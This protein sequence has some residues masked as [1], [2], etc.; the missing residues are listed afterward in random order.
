MVPDQA[1]HLEIGPPLSG[2]PVPEDG[3]GHGRNRNR[4]LHGIQNCKIPGS[5]SIDVL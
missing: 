2:E 5:F 1:A 4:K 3:E